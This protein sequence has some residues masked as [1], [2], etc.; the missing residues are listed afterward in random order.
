MQAPDLL[1]EGARLWGGPRTDLL[2]QG[3]RIAAVGSGLAAGPDTERL[4]AQGCLALPG[5]VDAHAHIDKTLWGLPWQPHQAGPTLLDRIENERRVM[6]ALRLSSEQQS[7]RLLRHMVARGTTHVRTHVDVGLDMAWP[8]CT[9][10]RPCTPRTA[11]SSTSRSS[12]S[13]RPG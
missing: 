6:Q 3:G 5:Y 1:I 10:C 9:A 4:L 2:L 12:P 11:I 8:T 13:P 7:A